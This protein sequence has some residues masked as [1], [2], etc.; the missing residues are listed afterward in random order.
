MTQQLLPF[1]D[2]SREIYACDM[3]WGYFPLTGVSNL[4]QVVPK[5]QKIVLDASLLNTQHYNAQ[6]K[7]KW[8]NPGKGVTP[9]PIRQC[10]GWLDFVAFQ[11]L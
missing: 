5:T 4:G 6:I 7:G 10:S 8:S 1:P 2:R 3:V 9:S 11:P